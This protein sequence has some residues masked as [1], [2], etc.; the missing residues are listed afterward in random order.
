MWLFKQFYSVNYKI[1]LKS[2]PKL[3]F[4]WITHAKVKNFQFKS[5]Q[6]NLNNKLTVE[7]IQIFLINLYVN[8]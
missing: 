4:C 2:N 6:T 5:N 8:W 1:L 3:E 7:N